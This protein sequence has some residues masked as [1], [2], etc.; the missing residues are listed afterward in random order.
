MNIYF[1]NYSD[2]R[3]KD[4]QK[5]LNNKSKFD[6]IFSFNKEDILKTNFYLEN[7]NI[8][9]LERGSGFCIWKPYLILECFNKIKYNDVLFYLDSAD[10]YHPSIFEFLKNYHETNDLILTNGCYINKCWTKRDTFILMG[11]D[12][13]E[14]WNVVQLEAGIISIKKTDFNI[15]LVNEWFN[16]CKNENI[17]TD[18][19]NIYGDN[20][21][22]FQDHRYDQSIL[23]NLKVKYNLTSN[24]VLRNYVICNVI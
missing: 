1:V 11:C 21:E 20:F 7:K 14:Y 23:T 2:D 18:M 13:P 15:K 3:Y 5:Y 22:C 24:D 16:F 8:L 10:D 4:H 19:P 17:L 12:K 6:D 9:D